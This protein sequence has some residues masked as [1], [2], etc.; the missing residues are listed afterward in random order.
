[1]AETKKISVLNT[2]TPYMLSRSGSV[3]D[4]SPIHPY[5]MD[6]RGDN[7]RELNR[8]FDSPMY[9]RNYIVWFYNNMPSIREK[10]K[11]FVA[12]YYDIFG[13]SISDDL[14]NGIFQNTIESYKPQRTIHDIDELLSLY[15]ELNYITNQEFLRFRTSN[16][17]Y[18]GDNHSV[19]FRISS[20]GFNWFDLIWKTVYDNRNWISDIT[21]VK[22]P[23]SL[24]VP[25]N[26]FYRVGNFKTDHIDV[27]DFVELNGNPIVERLR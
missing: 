3:L 14:V 22:D 2:A 19:Y 1:M 20:K 17:R 18:G 25:I 26:T 5:F 27:N 9:G 4:C 16:V 24:N 7:L 10:I 23:Q 13:G 15:E 6:I 8:L 11:V 12:S 21:I